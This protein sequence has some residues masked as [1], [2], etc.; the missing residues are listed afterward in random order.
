MRFVLMI[1]AGL[2][3]HTRGRYHAHR[4]CGLSRRDALRKVARELR[5]GYD[6]L[7]IAHRSRAR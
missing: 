4:F 3:S 7:T 1:L 2:A 6:A 5:A